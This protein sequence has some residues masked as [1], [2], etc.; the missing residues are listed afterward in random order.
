MILIRERYM[1]S[2]IA[3]FWNFCPLRTHFIS[4]FVCPETASK[5]YMY[6]SIQK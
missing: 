1:E 5:K 2:I 3:G 6:Y 4:T